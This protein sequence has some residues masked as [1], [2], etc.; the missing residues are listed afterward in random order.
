MVHE[1][2]EVHGKIRKQYLFRDI[3]FSLGF[4]LAM[5]CMTLPFLRYL[6]FFIPFLVVLAI[7]ADGKGKVGDEVKPFLA[8]LVAGVVLSPLANTEGLKDLFFTFA[9]ISVALLAGVP[10]VRLWTLFQL[11]FVGAVIYFALGGKFSTDMAYDIAK[12]ESPFESTFGFLFGVLAPFALIN[13][14]YRL[15]FLTLL[16]S[17]LCLK[18]IAVLGALMAAAFI[19]LGEKKGRWILNPV[20]MI[21]I[22]LILVGS[23]LAYGNGSFNYLIYEIT[24]QSA[25]QFGMGRQDL[26]AL[27]AREIFAHP[28]LFIFGGMGPGSS[29]DLAKL[30]YGGLG[31]VNLH[32]DLVKLLYEYGVVFFMIFIGL[33][34]SAKKY[35]T[36]AGFIFLN[37]LFLTDNTLIYYFLLFVFIYCARMAA[38]EPEVAKLKTGQ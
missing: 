4:V 5:L 18:R 29:Y 11:L 21:P 8:F 10:R 6:F 19:L 37:V 30:S 31:K 32:S 16:M 17:L 35:A 26:L 33:M 15:F 2:Q 24:G 38:D 3:V 34:Y 9:G 22:N 7:L 27:P 1:V 28:E 25:N 36:R 13:K 12:S 23:L 20:V 14:Q